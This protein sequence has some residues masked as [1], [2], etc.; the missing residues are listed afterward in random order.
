MHTPTWRDLDKCLISLT[1][2][3]CQALG[4]TGDAA[5]L[6]PNA[7]RAITSS[8]AKARHALILW[9]LSHLTLSRQIKVDNIEGNT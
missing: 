2:S 7:S 5:P 1:N 3:A 4:A 9:I 6:A 8:R